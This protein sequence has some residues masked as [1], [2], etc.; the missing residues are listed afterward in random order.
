MPSHVNLE[1]KDLSKF[2]PRAIRCL[3]W[4]LEEADELNCP[5]EDSPVNIRYSAIYPVCQNFCSKIFSRIAPGKCPCLE[6]SEKYVIATVR[7]I[8]E[9]KEAE[10][11]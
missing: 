3:K 6:Y 1:T 5:F 11:G 4:W 7:A 2:S 9:H 10:H 8:I